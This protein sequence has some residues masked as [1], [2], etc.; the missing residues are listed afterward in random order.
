MKNLLKMALSLMLVVALSVACANTADVDTEE[1][2][3][4]EGT[5]ETTDTQDGADA[6]NDE[7]SEAEAA[8]EEQSD[9]ETTESSDV[10]TSAFPM[11][12]VDAAE[13]EVVLETVPTRISVSY[14]PYWEYLVTLGITPVAAGQ[15]Q[16]YIDTWAP[17]EGYDFSEIVDLGDTDVNLEVLAQVAPDLEIEPAYDEAVE[18]MAKIAPTIVMDPRARMDWRFG[19]EEFG[20]VV[21]KSELAAQKIEEIDAQIDASRE[22]IAEAIDPEATVV[23]MSMMGKDRF[24]SAR[25]PV[26]FDN[27]EGLGLTAPEG[28]PEENNYEQISLEG[29]LEMDPD[30]LFVAVFRGD[31]AIYEET[32]MDPI[33]QSLSAVE[34]GHVYQLEGYAHANSIMSMVYTMEEMTEILTA[35]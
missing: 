20:K 5:T 26:L 1:T 32:A 27:E 9:D 6:S 23:V 25:K 18:N 4:T 16:H 3:G 19:L 13:R 11:T 31:E 21:G 10:D 7:A 14:L 17:F 33:W 24:F 28:Y 35:Q 29:L 8:D 2:A 12:Y 22:A 34:N 15:A 30:Y